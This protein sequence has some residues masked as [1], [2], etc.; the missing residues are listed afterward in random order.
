MAKKRKYPKKPKMSSSLQTWKNYE[1]KCKEVDK[2]NAKLE[3]EKKQKK[4]LI[5]KIRNK[6]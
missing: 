4:T 5:Q 2:F 6:Y 3:S 1:A